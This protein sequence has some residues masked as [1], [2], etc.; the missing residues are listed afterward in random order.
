[1]NIVR[2]TYE[3]PKGMSIENAIK[4]FQKKCD[5]NSVLKDAKKSYFFVKPSEKKRKKKM[6]NKKY[7]KNRE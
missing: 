2:V 1:M 5:T 3:V 4:N 7:N 6:E